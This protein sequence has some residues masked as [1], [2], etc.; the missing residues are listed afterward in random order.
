MREVADLREKTIKEYIMKIIW[1]SNVLFPEACSEIGVK[2]P[3]VGGWM[4]SG[5]KM[6]LDYASD[7]ELVV[8]SLYDGK[9]LL[10]IDKYAIK[11]YLVPVGKGNKRYDEAKEAFLSDIINRERPQLVHIHGTEYP[12]SLACAKAA[13][14]REVPVVVSIQG[15]V[16]VYA[17]YFMGGM[18]ETAIR[19]TTTFK[20]ILRGNGLLA[21]Q[22]EMSRRGV[23]E[24]ELIGSVS[25]VIGRTSWDK[26]CVWAINPKVK[27]HFCNETLRHAFYNT[28][29]SW[30]RCERHTIFLSQGHYPIKGL[31]KVLEALPFV[32]RHYPETK[33]V[34]A[35][36][37]TLTMPV[38]RLSGYARYCMQ[39]IEKNNLHNSIEYVGMLDEKAMAEQYAKAHVFVCPSSIENSPNSVGEA[40]LVGTP[41]IASYVGGSMDMVE[42]GKTGFLYRFEETPLLAMRICEIFANRELCETLSSNERLAAAS[43][44][45][46]ETNAKQLI[47]IY[48]DILSR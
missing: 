30:E 6:L 35:G 41:V 25:H 2:A 3:S 26:S 47:H 40:Q 28:T 34:L 9:R 15:L 14:N 43:R 31:H 20:D 48:N 10:C 16:S 38:Y 13:K 36:H 18:S 7:I 5:A 29:W 1:L 27:Y 37:K 22:K 33:I 19:K 24:R 32:L 45:D 44:H 8:V 46:G 21:Q 39:L 42:D 23:Y 4:A 11:Y 17:D 12:H